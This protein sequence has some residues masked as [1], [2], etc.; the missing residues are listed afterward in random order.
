MKEEEASQVEGET[1]VHTERNEKIEASRAHTLLEGGGEEKEKRALGGSGSRTER[2]Q[3][4]REV[5]EG[6]L[7]S[8]RGL[9]SIHGTGRGP[10]GGVGR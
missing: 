5:V 10:E 7:G 2:Y 6:G 9:R 1:K 3:G 4:R 8:E